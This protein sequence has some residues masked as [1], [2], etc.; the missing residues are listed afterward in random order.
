ML[1]RLKRLQEEMRYRRTPDLRRKLNYWLQTYYPTLKY[2]ANAF[3]RDLR[4]L[5]RL[6]D[7]PIISDHEHRYGTTDDERELREY[8]IDRM[9][10]IQ[11]YYDTVNGVMKVG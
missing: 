3:A 4:I 1:K 11:S 6:W 5:R 9:L 2:K 7:T 10:R 8:G